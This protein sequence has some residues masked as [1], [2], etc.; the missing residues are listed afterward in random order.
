VWPTLFQ[1]LVLREPDPVRIWGLTK[2]QG[3]ALLPPDEPAGSEIRR[4]YD[5][6]LAYYP[7]ESSLEG[8]LAV[9]E[10]GIAFLCAAK[11]WWLENKA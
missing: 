1:L 10:S 7:A 5:A 8:A 11:A 9:I 4:F 6:L 3:I 2:E